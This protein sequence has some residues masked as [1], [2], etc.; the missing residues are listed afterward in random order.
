MSSSVSSEVGY[1]VRSTPLLQLLVA[2]SGTAG[3]SRLFLAPG[4]ISSLP[5]QA[6]FLL[7]SRRRLLAFRFVSATI[8]VNKPHRRNSGLLNGPTPSC[9]SEA[10]NIFK[11]QEIQAHGA[12]PD[13]GSLG[14]PRCTDSPTGM[15]RDESPSTGFSARDYASSRRTD[16]DSRSICCEHT[17]SLTPTIVNLQFGSCQ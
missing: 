1:L 3:P 2:I 10:N 14:K 6:G 15:N 16:C 9:E 13:M 17:F 8:A 12:K 11:F 5:T 4:R 7:G